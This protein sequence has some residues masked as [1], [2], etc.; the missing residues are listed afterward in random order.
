MTHTELL[1][2][3]DATR[4]SIESWRRDLLL[5][6]GAWSHCRHRVRKLADTALAMAAAMEFAFLLDPRAQAAFDRLSR[7]RRHARSKLLRPARIRG[8][9]GELLRH[10][11]GRRAGASLVPP[12]ARRHADRPRRGA[13]LLV[14]LDVRIPDALAGDAR[15]DGQPA[16]ADESSDRAPADRLRRIA[17]AALGRLGIRLQRAR[18]RIHLSIF[19]LRRAGPR[20]QARLERERGHRALC[21]RTCRDGRSGSGDAKLRAAR[22]D[23]RARALRLLRSDRLHGQPCARGNARRDRARLHGAPP[24]NDD[25]LHRERAARC[26]NARALSCGAQRAGDRAAA[27]GADAARRLGRA[28]PSR[29]SGNSRALPRNRSYPKC[30]GFTRRTTPRRR[31]IFFRMGDMR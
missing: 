30:G 19:Q 13:D 22:G 1:F 21:D 29:G 4:R 14:G 31:R 16:R 10:R 27:A 6:P 5:A 2:W 28:S 20:A 11:Q 18:S 12:R 25:R 9:P 26:A 17:R 15:P 7:G 3:S 24:G 8:A 23:G